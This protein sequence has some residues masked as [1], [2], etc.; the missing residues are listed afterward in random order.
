MASVVVGP[1]WQAASALTGLVEPHLPEPGKAGNCLDPHE[2]AAAAQLEVWLQAWSRKKASLKDELDGCSSPFLE[3]PTLPSSW[4]VMRGV[5]APP[6]HVWGG[7]PR[8]STLVRHWVE[9][10]AGFPIT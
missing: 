7:P 9:T 1:G 2:E 5:A 4:Q 8:I 3:P 6:E 10:M